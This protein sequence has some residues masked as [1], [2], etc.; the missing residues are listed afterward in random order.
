MAIAAI[1]F[2]TLGRYLNVRCFAVPSVGLREG[3]LQEIAREVFSR[4]EPHR[5]NAAARNS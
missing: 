3:I 1:T 4:K 5:Y 2:I